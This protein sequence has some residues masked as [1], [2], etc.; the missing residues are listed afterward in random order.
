MSETADLKC[1]LNVAAA[2]EMAN[3][4]HQKCIALVSGVVV[5]KTLGGKTE[6]TTRSCLCML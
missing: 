3:N 2:K 1:L 4:W 6:L 5:K